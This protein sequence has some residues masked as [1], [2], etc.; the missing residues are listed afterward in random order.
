MCGKY[1]WF[2]NENS[3]LFLSQMIP[4]INIKKMSETD[5]TFH[6]KINIKVQAQIFV[7]NELIST[8]MVD[9]GQSGKM[10]GES[11]RFDI[12][13]KNSMTGWK[14]AYRLGC[15]SQTFTLYGHKG[16]YIIA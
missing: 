9:P 15:S 6:N 13:F 14:L 7:G 5:I 10:Q 8:C 11:R 1:L 3:R 12:Y 4:L 2:C 16:S